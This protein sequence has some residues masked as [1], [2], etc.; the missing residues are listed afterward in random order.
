MLVKTKIFIDP[1]HGGSDRANIG[2]TGYVEADGV[3]SISLMLKDFLER[4]GFKVK[5]SREKDETVVL[6]ERSIMSNNWGADLFVSVHTNAFHDP[7]VGGLE[8]FYPFGHK[9]CLEWSNLILK[10]LE[11]ETG[12]LNRGAK[13]RLVTAQNSPIYNKDYYS[14]IRETKAPALLLELGFHSNP[15]EED[16]LKKKCFRESLASTIALSL[17]ILFSRKLNLNEEN[18]LKETFKERSINN[19]YEVGLINNR[20]YWLKRLYEPM[21][22]WAV[23]TIISRLE[24][25]FSEQLKEYKERSG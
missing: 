19:L 9:D 24:N 6:R 10:D 4:L 2:P 8:I 11:E 20:E 5:M 1:G 18:L 23:M 3:L 22:V 21:P 15:E 14:V 17:F 25:S 16:K 13:T 7:K 12:W